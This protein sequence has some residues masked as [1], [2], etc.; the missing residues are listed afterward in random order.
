M[1]NSSFL[2]ENKLLEISNNHKYNSKK[3][4]YE[5]NIIPKYNLIIEYNY[6]NKMDLND[7]VY[8]CGGIIGMWFGWSALSITSLFLSIYCFFKMCM[9]ILIKYYQNR[10]I[11]RESKRFSFVTFENKQVLVYKK[12]SI[13]FYQRYK[14][15]FINYWKQRKITK[16]SKRFCFVTIDNKQVIVYNKQSKCNVM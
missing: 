14:F 15:I 7:L 1:K 10:K 5:I 12:S 16:E 3:V 8:N 4:L 6:K 13:C 11:I 9:N 2:C